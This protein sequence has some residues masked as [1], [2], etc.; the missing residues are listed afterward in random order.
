MVIE[1]VIIS[2]GIVSMETGDAQE[3]MMLASNSEAAI[4]M[5]AIQPTGEP[6]VRSNIFSM[7][8]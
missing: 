5:G 3:S 7:M 2:R 6:L 4:C 1:D 8:K